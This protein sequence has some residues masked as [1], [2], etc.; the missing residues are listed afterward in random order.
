MDRKVYFYFH[1]GSSNHGCEAIVRATQDL[2]QTRP[3]LFSNAPDD[4]RK[5]GIDTIV[6]LRRP[7]RRKASK[8]EKLSVLIRD[9]ISGNEK[10]GY[11]LKA[12][13]E[14]E[15]FDKKA[16]ALSIGGDNYCYGTAYNYH[17]AGLN[18]YLHKRGVKT[19]LWGCSVEPDFLTE[20]VKKDFSRYD[21]ITAR[22]SLSYEI[23]K[24]YNSNVLLICDPA[25]WL[26][27]RVSILP[28]EFQPDNTVGINVSPLVV[29]MDQK[30]IL[31]ENYYR[32]LEHIINHTKYQ[33]LLIPHVVSAGNDDRT[34]LGDLYNRYK[35]SGRVCML[36]DRGCEELKY[37]I[38]ACRMFIGA[39]TH[40]T[41]AA[42]SA[43]VPTLAVG[44]ST[45]AKGIAKDLFDEVRHYVVPIQEMTDPEGLKEAFAWLDKNQETVKNRL[46]RKIPDYKNRIIEGI[47]A[48][49][50]L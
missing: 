23:L 4:D 25:F 10:S 36:E 29:K 41:I 30:G 2:L 43:C 14:A 8:A 19:V 15:G 48:V 7:F 21:L 27:S 17:L 47:C 24:Q 39:R 28:Q 5:Y 50:E 35:E 33:I 18:K 9:K 37:C 45:K 6:D 46:T 40:A 31:L 49:R 3:V 13:C 32:L 34:V 11:Y 44:Y 42:Y 26:Q 22:E 1:A 12:R 38:S 16:V 20:E